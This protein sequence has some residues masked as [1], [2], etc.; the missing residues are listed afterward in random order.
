MEG[1][2]RWLSS[3]SLEKWEKTNSK[4]HESFYYEQSASRLCLILLLSPEKSDCMLSIWQK[5]LLLVVVPTLKS[6]PFQQSW[7]R[8][9]LGERTSES[10][11]QRTALG[12]PWAVRWC[13]F[14]SC[15]I[16][17]NVL[18]A[19]WEK[20]LQ[21]SHLPLNVASLSLCL[22]LKQ[23]ELA[24]GEQDAHQKVPQEIKFP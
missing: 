8:E 13:L 12:S 24:A 14:H 2:L 15:D 10:C 5:S 22:W 21:F 11:S 23:A 19:S 4:P 1:A 7:L 3:A 18:P 16:S 9:H 20:P 17:C 6:E